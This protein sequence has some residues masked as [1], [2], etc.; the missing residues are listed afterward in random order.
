V[1]AYSGAIRPI[2][3]ATALSRDITSRLP[4]RADWR[5][6]DVM[7]APVNGLRDVCRL[8]EL[9]EKIGVIRDAT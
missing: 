1:M 9:S 2:M 5:Q 3:S 4:Y 6:G 8:L 7:N